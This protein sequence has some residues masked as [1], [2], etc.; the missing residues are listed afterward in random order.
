M[1]TTPQTTFTTEQL[2]VAECIEQ[3]LRLTYLSKAI[4]MDSPE[5]SRGQNFGIMTFAVRYSI[6][7]PEELRPGF[8]KLCGAPDSALTG[9][10]L[11]SREVEEGAKT[12]KLMSE[13][14]KNG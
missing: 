3:C 14:A 7:M 4:G 8:Y 1:T 2:L 5:M 12:M 10:T 6:T 13:A 9:L 11:R